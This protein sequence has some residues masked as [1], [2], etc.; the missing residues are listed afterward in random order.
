M[1]LYML[2]HGRT[3]W[4]EA[5]KLQG[6][7]DIPLSEEGRQSALETGKEL[8]N[9]PFSAA[10]SSPLMRAK[11]TAELILQGRDI[12]VQTDERLIE[13]S[14]GSAEGMFL[15][16]LTVEKRPTFRLFSAPED[17][18][19]P[20]G[21]ESYASLEKRCRS[22]LDEIIV[23]NEKQWEHVLLVAHGGVVRGLFS[24]MFGQASNEIYGGHVQKNCAVNIIDCTAGVF[25]VDVFAGEYCEKL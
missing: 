6:R 15:S 24:A 12:P 18:I 9:I 19:P 13:L 3:L 20:E 23:P 14:F 4:N 1:K 7:T 25:S 5:G 8:A 17:Y 21:G 11:E 16:E 2:R 22:F 10:F